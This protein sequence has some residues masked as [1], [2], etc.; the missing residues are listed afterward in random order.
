VLDLLADEG[1]AMYNLGV[2]C[3]W[4][5]EKDNYAVFSQRYHMVGSDGIAL[6]PYGELGSFKFH[7]RAYGTFPRVIAKYVRSDGALKLEEAVHKMTLM[8]A[9]RAGLSDR[10]LIRKGMCA[11][12]VIFS[13]E[14]I[15]DKST[16]DDPSA[17]P[18][19]ID[20][21]IVNGQIVVENG[22]HTSRLPGKVLRHELVA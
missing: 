15:L 11:D 10:G 2:I 19:G 3:E 22:K 4:M 5:S 14:R 1:D 18:E 13:Y 8:P 12:I 21:V 6:A 9:R 17:Y 7:P 20:Y 16:Y